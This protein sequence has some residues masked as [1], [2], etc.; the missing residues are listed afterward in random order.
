MKEKK[1]TGRPIDRR[2]DEAMWAAAHA[3]LFKNGPSAV[4]VEAVARLAGLS[5]MTVYS[6]YANREALIAAVIQRQA[7]QMA[8]SLSF[9]PESQ[10]N[11]QEALT[12]FGVRLLSFLLSETHLGF[13]RALRSA[14]A[15]PADAMHTIFRFGP[16][17]TLDN[18]AQWM[19]QAHRARLA[20][21]PRPE[22]SAELLLG[23]LTGLDIVRAMYGEPCRQTHRTITRHVR[24]IVT[25]FLTLHER[26]QSL[27]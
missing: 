6:R 20:H 8:A 17:S 15:F 25:A 19:R 14:A 9:A 10:G 23:M 3:L 24:G 22:R 27:P 5:K 13:M 2:K 7:D 26:R 11:L 12:A 16:Q 4:S 21:I 1:R 18:L